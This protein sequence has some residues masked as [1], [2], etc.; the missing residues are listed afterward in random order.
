VI[1]NMKLRVLALPFAFVALVAGIDCSNSSG[2]EACPQQLSG[3]DLNAACSYEGFICPYTGGSFDQSRSDNVFDCFG[4]FVE[5]T[6]T[7]KKWTVTA[8]AASTCTL[9]S[10]GT[11]SSSSCSLGIGRCVVAAGTLACVSTCT[12]SIVTAYSAS[13]VSGQFVVAPSSCNGSPLDAGTEGDAATTDDASA[14]DA[15]AS[16]AG[17]E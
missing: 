11:L 3:L 1:A 13:C 16:D 6:C 4:D 17:D 7:Q 8:Q 5:Y 9:D 12:D 14:D 10:N 2:G 15:A